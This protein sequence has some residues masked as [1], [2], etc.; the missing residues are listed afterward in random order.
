M[1]NTELEEYKKKV[2]EKLGR[3]SPF[4]QKYALGDF[5]EQIDIP[6]EEDE[7]TELLVGLTLMADDFKEMMGEKESTIVKLREAEET[8]KES[9]ARFRTIFESGV[10]GTLFWDASGEITDANDAFLDIVGYSREDLLSGELKWRELTP[11]EYEEEDTKR[12]EQLAEKG[13]ITPFEKEYFHKSGRRIPIIL[14]AATF[15]G[16]PISG[17][18]FILDITEQKKL[19]QELL[20]K[21]I[22]FRSSIA[23][24][25]IANNEGVITHVNPAFVSMWGY[26]SE[27]DA[28]GN[29]VAD[30]FVNQ[31]DAGPVLQALG[32][33]GKWNGEFLAKRKEGAQFISRGFATVVKN[34]KGELMGYQSANLDVTAEV[35]AGKKLRSARERLQFLLSTSAAVIYTCKA[36][37]DFGATFISDNARVQMGYEP[38]EFTSDSG[39]W[40]SN[41]HPEDRERVLADLS[42]LFEEG[43]HLHEYRFR[44]S[45]GGYRWMRDELVLIRDE[46]ENPLE[47][48]GCW[49]DVTSQKE[50]EERLEESRDEL[51]RSNKELE[52]FAYVTSHDLQEPLRKIKSFTELLARRYQGQLDEKGDKYIS[53]ITGGATRMQGLINDLLTY[54]RV[55][56]RGKKFT[57]TS[58][59]T[60]LESALSN[61]QVAT[62]ESGAQV[63]HDPLPFIKA[64]PTQMLQLFQNLVGN[65]VKFRGELAPKVHVSVKEDGDRWLFRV[66]DNGIGLDMK[67]A[68]RIF[69]VFQRLHPRGEYPGTGIGLAV[70]R[71]IVERHGGRI[72]VESEPGKG[73]TFFFTIPLNPTKRGE[74]NEG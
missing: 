26:E 6:E 15:P 42:H 65:A 58:A 34:E 23:A 72:W 54:S 67:Q 39:F 12:L 2:A 41:I 10:I 20:L 51:E 56:T 38:E 14:G 73:S 45:D 24:G 28:I 4:L 5:S 69:Q 37:G 36:F 63:T 21:D 40:A 31:E 47:I 16:S 33:A 22:V 52:Q 7:F 43:H 35:E 61:L 9:E 66:R 25:S 64:D 55:S 46:N 29:S 68:E 32:E 59:E 49:V 50:I 60:V 48:V 62:R 53:Y 17:V 1:T 30:F 44:H 27:E 71:R 11:P 13:V 8:L 57:S 70:C 3:L 74:E 19:E 18:A